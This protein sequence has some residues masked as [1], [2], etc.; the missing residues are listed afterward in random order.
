M[1]Y[2]STCLTIDL[3]E[4]SM[5]FAMDWSFS[6]ESVIARK[7]SGS[8]KIYTSKVASDMESLE[9]YFSQ[10]AGKKLLVI[11]E[12]T[13]AQWLYVNLFDVMDRIIICDPYRNALMK[14]GSK[15]DKI[16]AIKLLHLLMSNS[17]K[18]VYHSNSDL[19]ELR[20]FMSSY[21]A[22]VKAI[23]RLKNQIAAFKRSKG[24]KKNNKDFRPKKKLELFVYEKQL[25][26]LNK[27]EQNKAEYESQMQR[28]IR[29]Y[30]IAKLLMTISGIGIVLSLTIYSTVIDATRFLNKYKYY[31]YCGLV[32]LLKESGK[33]IK[34]KRR[35]HYNPLMKWAYKSAAKAAISG[36]NDIHDY[37]M[38][39]LGKG[40]TESEA[41][42]EIARYI[43]RV[44]L[45]MM[46][47]ETPYKPYSWRNTM[48]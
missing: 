28:L 48:K 24:I 42:N 19:Y 10:F 32:L 8:N 6:T 18:G 5:I 46:K 16:D 14:E 33:S 20:S 13:G 45:A 25:E 40:Y 15:T 43:C 1:S 41:R 31:G 37:Y 38:Y 34:G 44:S 7:R 39:L 22:L 11:E 21:F 17:L 2:E 36:K 4:Y 47:H 30:P 12:T 23:V 26:L 9:A 35:G 3:Q 29:K 27:Y